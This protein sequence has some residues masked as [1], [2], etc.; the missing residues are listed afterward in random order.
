MRCS[1]RVITLTIFGPL[2]L[3]AD[4]F[5]LL[6]SEIVGDVEGFTDLL[7]RLAL[8][9]VGHGF[10]ANIKKWLDVEV[11]GGQNDLKEHLLVHLHKL[12]VP[13][14]N[15]CCSLARVGVIVL[16]LDGVSTV[17]LAPL[18][19][20]AED[21]LVDILYGDSIIGPDGSIANVLQQVLDQ[22]RSLGN[23]TVDF[24]RGM[25]TRFEPDLLL[26]LG[27]SHFELFLSQSVVRC[28][29]DSA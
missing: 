13:L 9:H 11:V 20:L 21:R 7:W 15:L 28:L 3:S 27:F 19:D 25:V 24:N 12:L 10:A 1:V 22:H 8:D 23:G 5:L 26:S 16:R 6:R 4:L 14:L 2:V 29:S 18:N 17:V